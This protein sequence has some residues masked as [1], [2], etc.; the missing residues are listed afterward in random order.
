MEQT[1]IIK[2]WNGAETYL[3]AGRKRSYGDMSCDQDFYRVVCENVSSCKRN[4][5]TWRDQVMSRGLQSLF[6]SLASED[7]RYEI[8]EN[9]ESCHDNEVVASGLIKEL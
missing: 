2:V 8:I 4:L 1:Y 7:G 5:K 3:E 9:P 6:K